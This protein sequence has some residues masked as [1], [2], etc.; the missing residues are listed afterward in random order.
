MI[1]TSVYLNPDAMVGVYEKK[2]MYQQNEKY[3]KYVVAAAA[4]VKR[5]VKSQFDKLNK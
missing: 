5:D 1:V 4:N 2:N 3:V